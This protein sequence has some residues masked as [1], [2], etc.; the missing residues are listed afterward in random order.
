M[1]TVITTE[2]GIVKNKLCITNR[3]VRLV[4]ENLSFEIKIIK[5]E[6]DPRCL[7]LCQNCTHGRIEIFEPQG[8]EDLKNMRSVSMRCKKGEDVY[9]ESPCEH[10]L[11]I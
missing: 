8:C 4:G 1:Q 5:F 10:F 6:N 2:L 3:H 9:S 11:V 7:G